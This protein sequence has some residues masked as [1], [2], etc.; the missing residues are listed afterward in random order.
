[1]KILYEESFSK[2]LDEI[3]NQKLRNRVSSVI[4]RIKEVKYI[5]DIPNLK[6]LQGFKNLYRVRIGDYR[7]GIEIDGDTVTVMRFKD[8]KDIYEVFP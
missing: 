6:K 5:Q 1:M 3:R 2:D 8:R 4:D 7:L